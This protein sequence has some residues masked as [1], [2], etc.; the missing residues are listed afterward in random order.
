[1][2]ESPPAVLP[3]RY[4]QQWK[5]YALL[6]SGNGLKWERFGERILQRPEPQAFAVV[7]GWATDPEQPGIV[8]RFRTK[9]LR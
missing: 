8:G 1:M 2:L 5:D 6:D 7:N 9:V 3:L 4:P